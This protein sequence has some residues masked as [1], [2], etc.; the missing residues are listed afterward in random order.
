MSGHLKS[1]SFDRCVI[2]VFVLAAFH[3]G[4]LFGG[5]FD[6]SAVLAH[7]SRG[8]T[9]LE[10]I[11]RQLAEGED[12]ELVAARA[13]TLA[14]HEHWS[15][16]LKEIDRAIALN[17]EAADYRQMR[18]AILKQLGRDKEAELEGQRAADLR[19][20]KFDT[21]I[22]EA[23]SDPQVYLEAARKL[24]LK[25]ENSRSLELFEAYLEFTPERDPFVL[26]ELASV[27][28]ALGD[29]ERAI[30]LID[31]ALLIVPEEKLQERAYLLR[32]R[33]LIQ[34]THGVCFGRDD[35]EVELSRIRAEIE[36]VKKEETDQ[37]KEIQ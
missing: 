10:C 21:A 6:L 18:A 13:W 23:G 20:R 17:A 15:E 26:R 27:V 30:G 22:A 29:Y 8:E 35:D 9:T 33:I 12:S 14:T 16:A 25:G 5:E 3:A 7:C 32:H 11:D 36:R 1:Q 19:K 2:P 37:M 34:Q 28:S 24:G 4:V 31:E